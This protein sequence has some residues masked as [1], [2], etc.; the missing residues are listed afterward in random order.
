MTIIHHLQILGTAWILLAALNV[1]VIP[2]RFGWKE[3]LC[4]LSPLTRQVFGVHALFLIVV[5]LMMG[6]ISLVFPQT[7]LDPTPLARLVLLGMCF[8][9]GLRLYVQWF[10]YDWRL[11]RGQRFETCVH[12]GF[13]ML[14]LYATVVYGW[15][16][17]V[18]GEMT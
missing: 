12:I 4:Q 9:W 17:W 8:F 7:L 16:W 14:W 6:V 15:A 13:T 1:W 2:R 11:W 10:V 5:L 18:V 3:E